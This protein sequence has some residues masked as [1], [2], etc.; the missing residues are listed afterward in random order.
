MCK[1]LF[2]KPKLTTEI[3]ACLLSNTIVQMEDE[4]IIYGVK[5]GLI[6]VNRTEILRT[7]TENILF[8]IKY[9]DL[10]SLYF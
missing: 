4:E 3:L 1:M 9:H 8:L 6:H 7:Q 10:G 2:L 5:I